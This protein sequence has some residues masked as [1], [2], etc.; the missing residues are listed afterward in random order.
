MNDTTIS[1]VMPAYNAA[2]FISEAVQSVLDQS[3]SDLELVVVD[4]GSND[5]TAELVDRFKDS[6]VR[7]I[8]QSNLGQSHAINHGVE[9]SRGRL[10]KLMDADDSWLSFFCH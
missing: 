3:V 7:L 2:P 1:V 4:D 6:R 9:R 8:K 10:I 5:D